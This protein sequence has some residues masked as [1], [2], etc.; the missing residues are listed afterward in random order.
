MRSMRSVLNIE[1]KQF[2]FNRRLIVCPRC[3]Y[4]SKENGKH[5]QLN[6]RYKS[7]RKGR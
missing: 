3:P 4:N 6:D 5:R 1:R 7:E 2:L